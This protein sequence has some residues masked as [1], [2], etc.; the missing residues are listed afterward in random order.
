MRRRLPADALRPWPKGQAG[1]YLIAWPVMSL[2]RSEGMIRPPVGWEL[3]L[4]TVGRHGAERLRGSFPQDATER[5]YRLR[6]VL[7]ATQALEG[8]L[9]LPWA[10]RSAE[11]AAHLVDTWQRLGPGREPG[12]YVVPLRP[13]GYVADAAR[14]L[15]A[16]GFRRAA[17]GEPYLHRSAVQ[18]LALTERDF[19]LLA[20]VPDDVP[21]H[22]ARDLAALGL[23]RVP[24]IAR[25]VLEPR[26][27]GV[28]ADAGVRY[29]TGR[30]VARPVALPVPWARP[31]GKDAGLG[32]DQRL[33]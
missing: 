3:T 18:R 11:D 4:G 24:T 6:F 31:A 28:L 30:A 32:A 2:V 26:I 17:E 8:F 19:V 33:T 27:L 14:A 21:A 20:P 5:G 7:R 29:A 1:R 16:E 22:W 13:A 9:I 25:D 15:A 23:G 12:R 10:V